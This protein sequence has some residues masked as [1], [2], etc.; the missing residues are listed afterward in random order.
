MADRSDKCTVVCGQKYLTAHT[1]GCG[2]RRTHG[3][4]GRITEE[5]TGRQTDR[6][7]TYEVMV[8]SVLGV[9]LRDGVFAVDY[10]QLGALLKRVLLKTQQVED[11]PQGLQEGRAEI[12]KS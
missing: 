12:M 11:A 7:R 4:T 10:L 5:E 9:I 8:H 1:V 2:D 6:V 3:R